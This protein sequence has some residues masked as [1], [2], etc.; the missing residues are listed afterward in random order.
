MTDEHVEAVRAAERLM[1][2]DE[3]QLYEEL[4]A[5]EQAVNA[6]PSLAHSYDLDVPQE[7][8]IMGARETVVAL[9]QRLFERWNREAHALICGSG[10]ADEEDRKKLAAAFGVSDV[11]VAAT[12]STMLATT[13][14]LAAPIAAV[15]AAIVV[16]RFGR[17]G[18]EE[19]CSFWESRLPAPR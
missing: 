8:R 14:G 11:V 15:I 3:A 18:Y 16:K 1:P 6:D 9:G 19:F 2:A 13:L 4:A 10:K 7:H 5:R 17:P 12:F